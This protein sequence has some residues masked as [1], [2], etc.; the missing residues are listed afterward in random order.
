MV[1]NQGAFDL[2]GAQPVAGDVDHVIDPTHD[3]EV[4]V[5]VLAGAV[6]R[7]IRAREP[8]PVLLNVPIRVPEDGPEH[9]RPGLPDHQK[10]ALTGR[11][12]FAFL[13][14]HLREDAKEWQGA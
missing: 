8:L 12:F 14:D 1:R 10:T 13:V 2:H 11:D 9:G 3:P 5:L 6:T 7:E 4:P